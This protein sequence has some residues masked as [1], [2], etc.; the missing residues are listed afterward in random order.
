MTSRDPERGA[1]RPARPA[2][3]TT[4]SPPALDWVVD[5]LFV[6]T[7]ELAACAATSDAAVRGRITRVIDRIDQVIP[8][9]RRRALAGTA[10]NDGATRGG[11]ARERQN[12][13]SP[14]RGLAGGPS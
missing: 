8:E 13:A 3:T 12:G 5:E 6:A 4:S 11:R 14:P 1:G 9:L 7:L 2:A 10:E